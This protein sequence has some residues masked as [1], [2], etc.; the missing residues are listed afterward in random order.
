[1]STT[2]PP[3]P[4]D[5][6]PSRLEGLWLG[7]ID[8][9]TL[10]SSVEVALQGALD[11]HRVQLRSWYGDLVGALLLPA[12][13]IPEL[14]PMVAA[15]EDL[16]LGVV[17]DTGLAGL[18]EALGLLADLDDRVRVEH[19]Q[20]ALP[21]GF[22]AEESATA[23]LDQLALS[24]TTYVELPPKAYEL[25]LD[26]IAA[27]GAERAAYRLGGSTEDLAGFVSA[28]LLRRVPFRIAGGMQHGA[29]NVLAAVAAG[30]SGGSAVDLTEV[31]GEPAPEKLAAVLATADLRGVRRA[32]TGFDCDDVDTLAEA[33]AGEGLVAKS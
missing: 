31:L 2:S 3:P 8:D 11:A 14:L 9:A 30:L 18:V 7:L 26:V 5:A 15:G 1:M 32:F 4:A 21:R 24:A 33:L 29:L 19:V 16:R 23:L 20:I 25:A 6:G 28:A 13:R 27:D 17:A 22:P 12:S 10:L